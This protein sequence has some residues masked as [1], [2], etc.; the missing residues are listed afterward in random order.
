M[1]K[2]IGWQLFQRLY[3]SINISW[4]DVY[5]YT[6]IYVRTFYHFFCI[7]TLLT[8]VHFKRTYIYIYETNEMYDSKSSWHL[9]FLDSSTNIKCFRNT[10]H[11]RAVFCPAMEACPPS[12]VPSNDRI[13]VLMGLVFQ[14]DILLS[15]FQRF[16][17]NDNH[18]H[19]CLRLGHESW[20]ILEGSP[21]RSWC[22]RTLCET[23]TSIIVFQNVFDCLRG[24]V[25]RPC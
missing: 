15:G 13:G 20:S 2:S 25:D 8:Y 14:L 16:S 7:N 1:C 5:I 12:M 6:Y 21:V 18:W 23:V 3:V 24:W 4:Y 10:C 11:W 9:T 22:H 19:P 17:V